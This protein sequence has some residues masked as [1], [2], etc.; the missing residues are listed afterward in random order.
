[1]PVLNLPLPARREVGK[2]G[3]VLVTGI[4]PDDASDRRGDPTSPRKKSGERVRKKISNIE[5]HRLVVALQADFE[6]IDRAAIAGLAP[7]DQ[8]HAALSA[9]HRNH[10]V[11]SIGLLTL[12]IN[13]QI[14]MQQHAAREERD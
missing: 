9:H 8:R 4:A 11:G 10:M 3:A 5:K 2:R 1:M 6:T 14:I 13:P 12:E 7:S